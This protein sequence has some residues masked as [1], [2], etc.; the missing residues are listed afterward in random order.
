MEYYN[1]PFI[2]LF[3]ITITIIIVIILFY[4]INKY[5]LIEHFC[6]IGPLNDEGGQNDKRVVLDDYKPQSDILTIW[7]LPLFFLAY[8]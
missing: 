8:A 3:T 7:R 2:I 4:I 5:I 1:T 6:K